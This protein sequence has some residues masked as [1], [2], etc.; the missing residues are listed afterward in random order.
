[1][2]AELSRRSCPRGARPTAGAAQRAR[3]AGRTVSAAAAL[4]CL[5][6]TVS[7]LQVKPFASVSAARGFRDSP[8][9][10]YVA[11]QAEQAQLHFLP[12]Q[13]AILS[14]A[15]KLFAC[16]FFCGLDCGAR[17]RQALPKHVATNLC[18]AR[19]DEALAKQQV[20]IEKG[21][22]AGIGFRK[23]PYKVTCS[24]LHPQNHLTQK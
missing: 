18:A 23:R 20:C 14:A 4:S 22:R 12:I 13:V 8:C 9:N 2:R 15:H 11:R 6:V 24:T 10:S 16:G 5:Q 19:S 7:S 1:M 3:H 21:L 17:D